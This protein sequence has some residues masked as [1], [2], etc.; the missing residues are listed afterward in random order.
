MMH[1]MQALEKT[2]RCFLCPVCTHRINVGRSPSPRWEKQAGAQGKGG[3]NMHHS[4]HQTPGSAFLNP[5]LALACCP[6]APPPT[7]PP[8]A[9]NPRPWVQAVR[10]SSP[11]SLPQMF[12]Q[13]IHFRDP[14][15]RLKRKKKKKALL[16]NPW[17]SARLPF[18][19]VSRISGW[20]ARH[21]GLAMSALHLPACARTCLYICLNIFTSFCAPPPPCHFHITQGK[22]GSCHSSTT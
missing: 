16:T 15:S 22:K 8:C 11:H 13:S 12:S 9:C 4:A 14:I 20:L 7:H 2:S 6:S 10:D 5:R 21:G 18:A 19:N 3:K 17:Q 1:T